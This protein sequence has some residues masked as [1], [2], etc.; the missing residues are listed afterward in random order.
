MWA[1]FPKKLFVIVSAQAAGI[2]PL[3]ISKKKNR[4]D[5]VTPSS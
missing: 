2:A 3:Y 1:Y 4:F 5:A